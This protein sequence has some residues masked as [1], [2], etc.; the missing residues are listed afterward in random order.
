MAGPSD[1]A[2]E[3][4]EVSR[5]AQGQGRQV[6]A[7][8]VEQGEQQGAQGSGSNQRRCARLGWEKNRHQ[9]QAGND[10]HNRGGRTLGPLA[11]GFPAFD[12]LAVEPGEGGKVCGC[13]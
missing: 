6:V 1:R 10:K 13:G 5:G 2:S 11:D 7:Q 3:Q 4:N 12:G 9:G 8:P